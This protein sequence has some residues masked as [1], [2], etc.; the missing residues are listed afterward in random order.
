MPV[1]SVFITDDRYEAAAVYLTD[2]PA[3]P[4]GLLSFVNHAKPTMITSKQ[5]VT[6]DGISLVDLFY[7]AA[8]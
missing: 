3:P 4:T 1:Y 7:A 6:A 2:A 5:A 8:A